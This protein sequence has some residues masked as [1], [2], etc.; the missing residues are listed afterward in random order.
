MIENLIKSKN[1][2]DV[3]LA[4]RL[5]TPYQIRNIIKSISRYSSCC[6]LKCTPDCNFII[7][8]TEEIDYIITR[9]PM[10]HIT[11]SGQYNHFKI[12]DFT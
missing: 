8:V 11:D 3:I 1:N 2:E 9:T 6:D 12:I 5:S 7:K 10:L 4:L